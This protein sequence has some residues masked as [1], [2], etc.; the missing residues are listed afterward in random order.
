MR[1]KSSLRFKVALGFSLF[2]IVLLLAQT[3]GVRALEERQEEQ[4]IDQMVNDEM[5]HL[6]QDYRANPDMLPPFNPMLNGYVTRYDAKVA[7]PANLQA[8]APGIHEV[9]VNGRELHLAVVPFGHVRLY[10]IYDF[11]RYER[12]LKE[13]VELLLV[14][15]GGFALLTIWLAFGLSGLLIGQLA[16]LTRQV[17]RFRQ[18]ESLARLTGKYNEDEVVELAQA[19]NSYHQRMAD[20]IARE[21]EFTANISHELRTPLTAILT[22]CELLAQ[23]VAIAEKSHRRLES[24]QRNATRMV[25]LINSLL[26]LAREDTTS[27]PSEV[28]IRECVEQAIAPFRE[29]LAAKCVGVEVRIDHDATLPL[30]RNA[31]ALVLANLVKNAATYTE[32]GHIGVSYHAHTLCVEDTGAGIAQDDLPHVFDKFYRGQAAGQAG[33]GLGLAI[34]KRVCDRNGWRI[35]LE[36]NSGA[37]TR[38]IID[39]PLPA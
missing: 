10:R 3:L 12:H 8:F 39:F 23:D 17:K 34:V 33:L 16:D 30:N 4:M 32:H 9:I 24:I 19:F 1:S 13:F 21:K 5:T 29:A 7:L 22:S 15:T 31:L 2:T 28:S 27:H 25:E 37:G 36:S 6:I 26:L 35:R 18:G 11:S 38:V 20:M 14:G